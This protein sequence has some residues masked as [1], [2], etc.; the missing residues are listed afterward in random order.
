MWWDDQEKYFTKDLS[1]GHGYSSDVIIKTFRKAWNFA[2]LH[3]A[4]ITRVERRKGV[5]WLTDFVYRR[6]EEK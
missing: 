1:Q 3:K 2:V 4:D 6:G 5:R